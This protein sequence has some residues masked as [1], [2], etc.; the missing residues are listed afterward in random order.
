[1]DKNGLKKR[2]KVINCIKNTKKKDQAY[3]KNMPDEDMEIIC[4]ACY[5]ILQVLPL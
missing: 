4:E 2:I 3:L 1:M 5:N